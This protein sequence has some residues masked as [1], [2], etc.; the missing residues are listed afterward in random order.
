MTLYNKLL[1]IGGETL[2]IAAGHGART[3]QV[4]GSVARGEE[5]G[6]SDFDLFVEFEPGTSLL[7]RITLVQDFEDLLDCKVDVVTEK[8]L[9]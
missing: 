6:A 4:F 2:E 7:N 9:H 8:G 5:I 1:E 3:V